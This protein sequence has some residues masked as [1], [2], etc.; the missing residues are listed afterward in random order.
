MLNGD[1]PKTIPEIE[2]LT[3]KLYQNPNLPGMD[4][5]VQRAYDNAVRTKGE[6]GGAEVLQAMRPGYERVNGLSHAAFVSG[7]MEKAAH[8]ADQ[9][10][11]LMPNNIQQKTVWD[12][13]T[14]MFTTTLAKPDGTSSAY[15][16]DPQQFYKWRAGNAS[17]FDHVAANGTERALQLITSPYARQEGALP[18]GYQRVQLPDGRSVL[19]GPQGQQ[20]PDVGGGTGGS[21]GMA[22]PRTREIAEG[23]AGVANAALPRQGG[24]GRNIEPPSELTTPL[25]ASGVSSRIYGR[26]GEFSQ[27]HPGVLTEQQEMQ[28]RVYR[29]AGYDVEKNMPRQQTGALDTSDNRERVQGIVDKIKPSTRDTQNLPVGQLT[30][31][32]IYAERQKLTDGDERAGAAAKQFQERAAPGR[33]YQTD[34]QREQAARDC[35]RSARARPSRWPTGHQRHRGRLRSRWSSGPTGCCSG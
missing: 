23:R 3:T 35:G 25:G 11:N 34:A 1:R 15:Q 13:S 28:S 18:E 27:A 22:D 8:F 10:H 9:A 14:G 31:Q 30:P 6:A 20:L 12:K 4:Q 33:T 7:D 5:D 21:Q 2:Q 24:G 32:E 29:G 26:P 16:M 17:Q 19:K